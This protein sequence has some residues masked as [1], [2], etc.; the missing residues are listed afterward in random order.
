M[1]TASMAEIESI[2]GAWRGEVFALDSNGRLVN[3]S[4]SLDLSFHLRSAAD[5]LKVIPLNLK[6]Q[7]PKRMAKKTVKSGDAIGWLATQ[8]EP[9]DRAGWRKRPTMRPRPLTRIPKR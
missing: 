9:L 5:T 6:A 3:V 2:E 7:V 1:P 8:E 4:I